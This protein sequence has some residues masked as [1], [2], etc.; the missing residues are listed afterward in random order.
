MT[1]RTGR[2]WAVSFVL[3]GGVLAADPPSSPIEGRQTPAITQDFNH[4]EAVPPRVLPQ[5]ILRPTGPEPPTVSTAVF[6]DARSNDWKGRTALEVAEMYFEACE[7]TEART[8]YQEVIRLAPGSSWAT[9]AALR[10]KQTTVIPAGETVE[11]PLAG[12]SR[13]P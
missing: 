13:N 7:L 5:Q 9:S 10:L 12:T 1:M 8:W 4:P 2:V 11:P 6:V 3:V